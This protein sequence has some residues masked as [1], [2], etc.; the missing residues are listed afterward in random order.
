MATGEVKQLNVR[1][2]HSA[3][4][5]FPEIGETGGLLQYK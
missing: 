3:G 2:K 4:K 5:E 1:L